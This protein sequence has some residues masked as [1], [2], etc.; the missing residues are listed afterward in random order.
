M[1]TVITFFYPCFMAALLFAKVP[2]KAQVPEF[3]IELQVGF[4]EVIN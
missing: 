1:I 2:L 3:N 4:V